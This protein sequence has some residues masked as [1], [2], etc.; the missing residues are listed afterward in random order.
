MTVTVKCQ[1]TDIE[2]EAKSKRSKNHPKISDLLASA[3]KAGTYGAV[4]AALEKG[5]EMGLETIEQFL[6]IAEAASH[7][8]LEEY[9]QRRNEQRERERQR[10][11]ARETRRQRNAHLRSHG[12]RWQKI[13]V[14]TEEATL[15]G[16]YGAG[17]GEYSHEEWQLFAPDGRP[18]SVDRALAEIEAQTE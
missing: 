3:N 15:P 2:F 17:I 7:D 1:Y 11:E 9:S 5:R 14:G 8:K 10:A 16:S 18:V 4:K 12:Y 6:E 13:A